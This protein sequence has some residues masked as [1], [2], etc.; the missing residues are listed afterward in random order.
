M[1]EDIYNGL[2]P[3]GKRR[4]LTQAKEEPWLPS[5]KGLSLSVSKVP[6]QNWNKATY[7]KWDDFLCGGWLEEWAAKKIRTCINASAEAVEVGVRCQR[8]FSPK[9]EFEIDVA[10]IRGHRLYVVSC[11]TAQKKALC[12]SKLFE[13]AMRAR[14]MGGDLARSAL[15]CLLHGDDGGGSYVDQLRSDIKSLWDAPNVPG[16]FGL[17]DLREWHGASGDPNLES[18]RQWL[19]S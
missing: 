18:L 7:E 1:I 6:E 17:D 12:K 4:N 2:R 9:V 8:K 10:L 13:V 5:G 19:E 15:V 14:Q 3:K 16:V 11:S